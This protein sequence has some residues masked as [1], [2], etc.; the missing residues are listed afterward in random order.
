MYTVESVAF[1]GAKKTG[2]CKGENIM[3]KEQAEIYYKSGWQYFDSG[4]YDKA[5]ADFDKAIRIDNSYT[6]AF[7][8]RGNAY[9]KKCEYAKAIDDYSMAIQLE[10]NKFGSFYNARAE[11]YC[12]KT[13]AF[14]GIFKHWHCGKDR[15]GRRRA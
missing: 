14:K 1:M 5:I 8:E 2:A 15:K 10:P 11:A 7:F 12:K 3:T 6:A 9:F 13:W 4:E